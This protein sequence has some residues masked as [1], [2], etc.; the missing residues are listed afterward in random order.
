MNAFTKFFQSK[1]I[2]PGCSY[3]KNAELIKIFYIQKDNREKIPFTLY[4]GIDSFLYIFFHGNSE[5]LTMIDSY[6]SKIQK[7]LNSTFLNVE[8][9]GYQHYTPS[10]QEP[11]KMLS[12][13]EL[14]YDY[15]AKLYPE[16]KIIIFGRS[17]GTG[18]AIHLASV[19]KPYALILWSPFVSV[20][21]IIHDY[22]RL[23]SLFSRIFDENYV[24]NNLEKIKNVSCPILFLHGEQDEL[25]NIKQSETLLAESQNFNKSSYC[26]LERRP[27]MGHSSFHVEDDIVSPIK[28]FLNSKEIAQSS[29]ITQTYDQK[30]NIMLSKI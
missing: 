8:Y 16:K 15:A 3:Q 9:P 26:H 30:G 22:S 24:F 5:N 14:V 6:L 29:F 19:R 25:I 20:H 1:F 7:K 10:K 28:E 23:G 4:E 17:I 13:S 27:Y 11:E 2:L 12:D 21:K 18:P